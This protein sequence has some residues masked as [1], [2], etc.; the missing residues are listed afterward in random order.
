MR[1]VFFRLEIISYKKIT[2]EG[3][4]EKYGRTRKWNMV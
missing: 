1:L 3:I 4:L 2:K